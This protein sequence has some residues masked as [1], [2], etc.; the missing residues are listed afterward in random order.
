L[1]HT[2]Q[3]VTTKEL[4]EKVSTYK[5]FA[6]QIGRPIKHDPKTDQ[7]P[8]NIPSGYG[9]IPDMVSALRGVED[10]GQR[11]K[12]D[13]KGGYYIREL[14]NNS[15]YPYQVEHDGD[16]PRHFDIRWL[17]S[18]YAQFK[19]IGV[20]NRI[21]RMD[22]HHN[23]CGEVRFIY[24]LSYHSKASA[25]SLP[26]FLNV[27]REYP[28]VKDCK[29]FA[30]KWYIKDKTPQNLMDGPLKETKFQQLELNFQSL[31]FTSGYMHDFGGQAMYI[32]RI[33]RKTKD[34]LYPIP[35]ENTPNV[36]ALEKDKT[37][38]TKF[39]V[40]LKA[41]ENLKALDEGYL[42]INF[43]PK[44]LTNI[45]LSWSTLGRARTANRP[46]SKLYQKYKKEFDEIDVSQLKFIKSTQGLVERLNNLT[47]A[48]CHQAGGTAGFHFLGYPDPKF[49]HPFNRQELGLSPHAEAEIE[50]RK[51]YLNAIIKG[52]EPNRFRPHSILSISQW[53]ASTLIPEFT[54]GQTG[55][56][57]FLNNESFAGH[58]SCQSQ[59]DTKVTCQ[60][61]VLNKGNSV[62]IGECVQMDQP[63][64]GNVCWKGEIFEN[65][66]KPH[67]RKNPIETFNF[68]SFQ[69]KWKL[70]GATFKDKK[71]YK[72]V[73]PQSGAP[74]GRM[75]RV[76]SIDEEKFNYDPSKPSPKE[77]CANQG[78]K[79]F[80]LCAA[81]GDAGA[82][83][84]SKVARS[85]LDVCSPTHSCR[86]DYICQR[87]P[88]YSKI[89]KKDYM[90]KKGNKLINRV[91]PNEI[92][93]DLITKAQTNH[94]GFCVPTYF[95]FNMRLD[96][97]PNPVTGLSPESP[98]FDRT[99]PLRG[100]K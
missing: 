27:V 45:S 33:F 51:S 84:E 95:L 30:R 90:R 18:P 12:N 10:K 69:D 94:I 2:Q 36:L 57:C 89:S 72:C 80:D 46:Y 71:N 41:P 60:S 58:L 25:S 6:D 47:C 1:G 88:D 97:H 40:F 37:L 24:R 4:Y 70:I 5:D 92:R 54:S 81:S 49:S 55:S 19:L 9:D 98:K 43:D 52:K 7:L 87:F 14:S 50:R 61:T 73:L 91:N 16:E 85:M 31:R 96:G 17:Y 23:N 65:Y 62:L 32:Q 75:S 8:K 63:S 21:D 39:L 79:G 11:S 100:Y 20:S 83:L 56:L 99:K 13:K 29:T 34:H 3:V 66:N 78:G 68:Y 77:L 59:K 86:E 44:F 93:G 42:N 35:L 22:F 15:H 38:F 26:F 48:G 28:K 74:L 82:C 64:A 53:N 76:C 67:N